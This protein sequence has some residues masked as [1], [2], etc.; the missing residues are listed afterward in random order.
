MTDLVKK[1]RHLSRNMW[2]TSHYL[3]NKQRAI[4][5]DFPSDEHLNWDIVI[6]RIHHACSSERVLFP[7]LSPCFMRSRHELACLRLTH[8]ILTLY[9]SIKA[10]GGKLVALTRLGANYNNTI[11][12]KPLVDCN[13][14]TPHNPT[15]FDPKIRS[16]STK[17]G[18]GFWLAALTLVMACSNT[19]ES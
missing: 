7:Q 10:A 12:A 4:S 2:K 11:H 9:M 15:P 16:G 8:R 5:A 17:V 6:T 1:R 14:C 19:P 18:D 13:S 3:G